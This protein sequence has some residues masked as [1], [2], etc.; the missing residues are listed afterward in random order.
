ML[1]AFY[2]KLPMGIKYT[3][4]GVKYQNILSGRYLLKHREILV[5]TPIYIRYVAITIVIF[6]SMIAMKIFS[7]HNFVHFLGVYFSTNPY[8]S[9]IGLQY[10]LDKVKGV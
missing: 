7:L 4:F 1:V 2:Q 10:I 9:L 6:I 3:N 8:L 5:V